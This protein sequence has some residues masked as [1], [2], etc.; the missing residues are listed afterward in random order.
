VKSFHSAAVR[1]LVA[2]V[3]ALEGCAGMPPP[4]AEVAQA[5]AAIDQALQAGAR[6]HAPIEIK[7]ARQKLQQAHAAVASEY[8]DIARRL[9][10]QA[11]IEAELAQAKSQSAQAQLAV[12]Q[13]RESIRVL[14]EEIGEGASMVPGAP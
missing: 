7:S 3:L 9:A 5:S 2:A 8:Y 11:E 13:V 14:R 10:E 12:Q 4:E 1:G 6:D